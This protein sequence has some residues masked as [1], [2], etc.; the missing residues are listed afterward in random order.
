ME[1][2]NLNSSDTWVDPDDAPILTRA[3]FEK[4]ILSHGDVVI[5]RGRPPSGQAKQVISLRLDA[6]LIASLRD[7]GPGW[8][9]RAADA[10]RAM[11]Q[12][13]KAGA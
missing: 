12:Q 7:L 11:I 5:R 8:Q 2:K 9:A 10:L 3:F 4:G 6:D 1:T 13:A